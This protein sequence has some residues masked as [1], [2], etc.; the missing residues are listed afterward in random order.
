[1]RVIAQIFTTLK[2][3]RLVWVIPASNGLASV[4]PK[5]TIAAIVVNQSNMPMKMSVQQSTSSFL[6]MFL[7]FVCVC[8]YRVACDLRILNVDF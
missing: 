8:Y 7:A 5:N 6:A 4:A 3:M 2:S 1:M